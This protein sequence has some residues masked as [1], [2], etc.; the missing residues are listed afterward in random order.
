MSFKTLF[1]FPVATRRDSSRVALI[2]SRKFHLPRYDDEKLLFYHHELDFRLCVFVALFFAASSEFLK[3]ERESEEES[4]DHL[5]IFQIGASSKPSER[6]AFD[7]FLSK[8][9][10]LSSRSPL[11]SPIM[12]KAR[13]TNSFVRKQ[14]SKLKA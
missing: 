6:R 7:I 11:K 5:D 1:A 2:K 8:S 10:F 9:L 13:E 3:V 12:R 14:S 4:S